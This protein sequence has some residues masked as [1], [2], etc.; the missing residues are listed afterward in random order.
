LD[1][2]P[3][4]G[5]EPRTAYKAGAL[6]AE[7]RGRNR[8]G[9]MAQASAT[10]GFRPDYPARRP[11]PMTSS[12][13]LGLR[14]HGQPL[15][16][17]LLCSVWPRATGAICLSGFRSSSVAA[18]VAPWLLTV[19]AAVWP[20]VC[21][22]RRR[23]SKGFGDWR[24]GES[25]T[26]ARF[27]T[28]SITKPL[29]FLQGELHHL[30]STPCRNSMGVSSNFSPVASPGLQPSRGLLANPSTR[31]SQSQYPP[32][33]FPAIPLLALPTQSAMCS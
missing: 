32:R 23:Q 2:V 9:A 3:T 19:G 16:G 12:R 17:V 22:P 24:P 11:T 21:F 26:S 10:Q 1:L 18:P 5:I 31:L 4:R 14:P 33:N 28:L 13:A 7:L 20:R 8:N 6:P 30:R 27:P 25:L 29:R 15:R